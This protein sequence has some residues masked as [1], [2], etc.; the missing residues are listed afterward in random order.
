MRSIGDNYW[1][2]SRGRSRFRSKFEDFKSDPQTWQA[3]LC[4][5]LKKAREDK[6]NAKK[7]AKQAAKVEKNCLKH[8]ARLLKAR[9]GSFRSGGL[10]SP[11]IPPNNGPLHTPQVTSSCFA[12]ECSVVPQ[13]AKGLSKEDIQLLLTAKEADNT[14]D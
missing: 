5:E 2:G 13:A 10:L 11:N 6:D 4:D 14:G 8:R 12:S 7:A 3:L 1:G 9:H